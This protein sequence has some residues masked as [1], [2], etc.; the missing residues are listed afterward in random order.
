M[1]C[2]SGGCDNLSGP[3]FDLIGEVSRGEERWRGRGGD[4]KEEASRQFIPLMNEKVD[5]DLY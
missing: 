4:E 3:Y 1:H 5:K 2:F